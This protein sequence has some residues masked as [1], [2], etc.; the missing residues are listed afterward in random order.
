MYRWKPFV[1]VFRKRAN[2]YSRRRLRQ[3]WEV[4]KYHPNTS[5]ETLTNNV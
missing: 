2:L 4:D 1:G 3:P 5:S